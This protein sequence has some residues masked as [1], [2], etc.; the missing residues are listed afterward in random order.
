M[1][2]ARLHPLSAVYV[3]LKH[4]LSLALLL[5]VC[6]DAAAEERVTVGAFAGAKVVDRELALGT[7]LG[8]QADPPDD[9]LSYGGRV[10]YQFTMH[11][12][13][14]AELFVHPTRGRTSNSNMTLFGGRSH[15]LITPLPVLGL[16][17]FALAGA[18]LL[19]LNT[20]RT[21]LL[22]PDT[23]LIA[24]AGFGL[25]FDLAPRVALRIEMR[26]ELAPARGSAVAVNLELLA[27]ATFYFPD[28]SREQLADA[29]HDGVFDDVDQCLGEAE[30]QDG[31]DDEDGCP[32]LDN[33]HDG[34]PDV[35]DLCPSDAEDMAP[36]ISVSE[37]KPDGCPAIL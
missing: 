12:R 9:S 7:I 20:P 11:V 33:D 21:D 31:F 14:D 1:K 17:P 15:I 35:D 4:S 25:E 24:Y 27:G 22:E 19:A 8:E 5:V 26:T 18:G 6:A 28:A 2:S 13:A 32:D 3:S 37:E 10:G 34:I 30:D 16:R 29:D 23:N 36:E